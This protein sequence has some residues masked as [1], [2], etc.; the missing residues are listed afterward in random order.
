MGKLDELVVGMDTI[1]VSGGIVNTNT[2]IEIKDGITTTCMSILD[3]ENEIIFTM[4]AV[5]CLSYMD[6]YDDMITT[7]TASIN[8][9]IT[10][11]A[12]VNG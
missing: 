2:I 8:N 1:P 5:E 6:S 4:R 12:T 3:L 11:L 10:E 7:L 9:K